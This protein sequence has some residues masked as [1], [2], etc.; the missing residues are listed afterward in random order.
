MVQTTTD[1]GTIS[2]P[3][4]SILDALEGVLSE[5]ERT[6]LFEQ[7][8]GLRPAGV[9][10]GDL[11]TAELFNQV[12]SDVND[13]AQRVAVLE[14]GSDTVPHLPVITQ[15]VPQLVKTGQEFTVFGKNLTANL[16]SRID[17]DNTNIPLER[18]KDGSSPTRLVLDA[19]AIIG[20]PDTGATV[21]LS[22]SNPAGTGQGSYVQLPGVSTHIQA[23][24]A[25]TLK[26][27]TPAEAIKPNK[28]YDYSFEL[29]IQSSNDETF[30]LTP[31]IS[32]QGW[33]AVNKGAGTIPVTSASALNAVK[34][35]MVVTVTTGAS[36]STTLLL[37]VHGT[38]FPDF[39]ASSLPTP[40]T[41]AAAQPIPSGNI[42]VNT[43]TAIGSNAKFSNNTLFIKR[44]PAGG[45]GTITL[46]I[47]YEFAL[48]GSYPVGN[49]AA[50]PASDWGA[51]RTSQA[52]ITT[53]NVGDKSVVSLHITP[54]NNGTQYTA[55]DGQ[56]DF[57]VQ[58]TNG[59]EKLPFSAQLRIVDTLP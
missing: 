7:L 15:I 9:A 50:A 26:S 59:V 20:L 25:F 44:N 23:N 19:P 42:K 51:Q 57:L 22:V 6:A 52:T 30:V 27:V 46:S 1:P 45:P 14:G 21:I 11:I 16:L 56:L 34:A 38:N 24:I 2:V 55:A 3:M 18:I 31:Q 29:E 28:A 58:S 33:T 10:P 41:I 12:L 43:I 37:N 47:Q 49:P 40:I 53:T 17:V 32:G 5:A 54:K 8:I 13:L 39:N 35:T 4:S 36:G 48:V